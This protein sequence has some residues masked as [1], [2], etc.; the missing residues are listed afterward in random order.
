MKFIYEVFGFVG[1]F[2]GTVLTIPQIYHTYK[3]KDGNG[4]SWTFLILQIITC[5]IFM[6]YNVGLLENCDN[7]L[8][9]VPILMSAP[10]NLVT[11]MIL[12][13]LKFKYSNKLE[14][15]DETEPY[16]NLL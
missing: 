8:A 16:E 3:L 14:E 1:S 13:I 12:C 5:L 6:V 2:I 15:T 10:F 9:L 7:V 11:N 4:L